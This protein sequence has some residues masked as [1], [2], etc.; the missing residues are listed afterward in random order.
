MFKRLKQ[1]MLVTLCCV[2]CA[3]TQHARP[4]R[5]PRNGKEERWV[6]YYGDALPAEAFMDYDLVLFDRLYHPPLAPLL[7][8]KDRIVLAYISA[9]EV[10]GF[11]S[12]DMTALK[13][14]KALLGPNNDW[15]S[16]IV[17][18]T[19]ATWRDIVMAEVKDAA[20]Q[21]FHGVMLDTID[22]PLATSMARS[23]Q[24][25]E[26]NRQAAIQL[27]ADIRETYP[28]L[29]IML[30]RGFGI[31]PEVSGQL[32]FELAESILAE[33]NVS[34]G[35]SRLFSP[36][37][38][39]QMTKALADV[40]R[41]SP[42]LKIYALDYWNTDDVDGIGQLYAIHREH[43]FVPYVSTPDLRTLTPEP[44]STQKNTRAPYKKTPVAIVREDHDA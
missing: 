31:L 35:Q 6:V 13:K 20:A 26:A 2:S 42:Q 9:G 17:D 39:R 19:S 33:T 34:T 28:D 5:E 14:G 38:Y 44:H 32:D 18:L 25:G 36:I 4:E 41:K 37:N 15:G 21:G 40:R 43:G 10:H 3:P 7:E 29:K 1:L 27:I 11:R 23:P 12:D 22:T 30:N 8:D 24:L 16:Y